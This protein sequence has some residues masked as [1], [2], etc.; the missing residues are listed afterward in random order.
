MISKQGRWNWTFGLVVV[1]SQGSS[2]NIQSPS[3]TPVLIQSFDNV[4]S[5]RSGFVRDFR[6]GL[7]C[8]R[9]LILPF[10]WRGILFES[11][12]LGLSSR[13]TTKVTN[14]AQRVG[15]LHKLQPLQNP[16]MKA[17]AAKPTGT[18][19]RIF[20]PL[21]HL[22]SLS[23]DWLW[24]HAINSIWNVIA[25]IKLKTYTYIRVLWH[26]GGENL[27]AIYIILSLTIA[28]LDFSG[29]YALCQLRSAVCYCILTECWELSISFFDQLRSAWGV[30]IT[31][32]KLRLYSTPWI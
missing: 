24:F 9:S 30:T 17:H 6:D 14:E 13:V 20:I 21:W 11:S 26:F 4:V 3:W 2:Q 1:A 29:I 23:Y 16:P 15:I 18:H 12:R 8:L 31:L 25:D 10:K 7:C 32:Q 5:E 22:P 27:Q 19:P 28:G